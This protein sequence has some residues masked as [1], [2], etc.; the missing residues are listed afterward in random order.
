[1]RITLDSEEQSRGKRE[2]LELE[3]HYGGTPE[4]EIDETG[5]LVGEYIGRLESI[6]AHTATLLAR[7]RR[8]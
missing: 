7:S 6:R 3:R 8:R 4:L 2:L 5:Q 1:M